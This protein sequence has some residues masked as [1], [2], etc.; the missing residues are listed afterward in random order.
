[1]IQCIFH[2]DAPIYLLALTN[3]SSH[4][5]AKPTRREDCVP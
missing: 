1:M 4:A 2:S 5:A 3:F